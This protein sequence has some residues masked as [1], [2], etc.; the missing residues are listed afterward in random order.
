MN[1]KLYSDTDSNK[2]TKKMA[3]DC[4]MH[5]KDCLQLFSNLGY[6]IYV[7]WQYDFNNHKE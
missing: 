2:R 7:I 6:N 3:K 1:P 5:D 4:W